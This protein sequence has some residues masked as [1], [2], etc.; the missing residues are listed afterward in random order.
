M[1]FLVFNEG[2]ATGEPPPSQVVTLLDAAIKTVE[3]PLSSIISEYLPDFI[4][5]E[6]AGFVDFMEA[7]YEWLE[8][9]EN[10]YGTSVT[11]MD[12]LDIDRTLDSFVEYF[13]ETYLHNF[14]KTYAATANYNINEKTILKNIN[15]FYKAKGTEKS[16]KFLFR[17]LHD[18]DVLFYYPK[19][20]I[21]RVSDGKWVENKSIKVTSDNGN[22][23][24]SL[25]DKQIQQ[26][27][28]SLNGAI[29]AYANVD[30]VYQYQ[31]QQY[32]VTELFLTDINGTFTQGSKIQ[33]T[34]DGGNRITERIYSIPSDILIS[35]G[36]VGYRSG[37][38]VNVDE[39]SSNYISGIGAKGSVDRVNLTGVVK[40]AQIN[41]FGVDYKSAN[42]ENILPITFR[43]ASGAGASGHVNLDALCTYPGYYANNDGKLS[44]NKK[45]RDNKFYQEY[46]YVLKTEISLVRYKNQVKNL[47]HPVG[48]NL[49]GNISIFNT[50]TTSSAYSTQLHQSKIPVIGRYCPY[51]LETQDSLRSAT[52]S[53]SLV[54]LYPRGFNPGS[55]AANHCLGN[56][57]GRLAIKTGTAT[58]GGGYTSGSFRIGEG[59]TGS[60]T[61]VSG[62]VFGWWRNTSTGGVV[63][64]N[65]I[66]GGTALG[67]TTGEMV[68]ATGGITGIV[69]YVTVGN[70][71]VYEFGS[72]THITGP[73]A[74]YSGALTAGAT[75]YGSTGYWDVDDSP[76]TD[77]G[78]PLTLTVQTFSETKTGYTSGYDFTI[79][80][81]ITQGEGAYNN[82][83]RGIVKDW[84][85]GISG[86]T[87]NT[88]KI[89]LTFGPNFAGGTCSEIDNYDGNVSTIYGVSGG[90]SEEVIRN[91]IKHLKLD[92]VVQ[93]PASWSYHSDHGYTL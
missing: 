37:D 10:P 27:D 74:L 92:N 83:S 55:T 15:D 70:G 1:T 6:H 87:G 65:T 45:I 69:E 63:F 48:T 34:L 5:N 13:R 77:S 39:T 26:I 25:K 58:F 11:L 82:T 52:G 19:K 59:I 23:N 4:S 90:M 78:E 68:T 72:T 62:S 28:P 17:I 29:T 75:A 80:N 73:A 42:T 61:G 9:K 64:L 41:N 35:N 21:L 79:G 84:I 3:N 7:Y 40:K 44:S 16:Y 91:K 14:P 32:Q 8:Y 50:N 88:L 43:S 89:L 33:S 47:V 38:V 76:V 60:S 53:G 54:D 31:L 67:F 57:G 30:N 85:P 56:T 66:G 20:D 22:T 81:V 2:A 46:S 36:G 12:T 71:T 51:T 18:S 49:F 86:G 24:F 93:L